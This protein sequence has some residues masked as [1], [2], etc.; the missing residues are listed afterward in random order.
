PNHVA[1]LLS[2]D[3]EVSMTG[4]RSFIANDLP[5]LNIRPR[6]VIVGEPTLLRPVIAHNGVVRRPI[7]TTGIAAHTA[8]P[9]FGRSAILMMN[10]VIHAVQSRY[11]DALDACHPLTG[12]AVASF[13]MIRGGTQENIIPERCDVVVDQRYLP[14]D[15]AANCM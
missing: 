14:G 10:R 8:V 2:V 4:I 13:T 15:T 11:M 9:E 12:R 7:T 5:R 3:E 1:L 6:G